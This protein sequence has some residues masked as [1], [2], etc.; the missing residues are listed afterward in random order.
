LNI[1]EKVPF[2]LTRNVVDGL[3]P[4]GTNGMF[5][6]AAER[7]LTVL[8]QNSEALLTILSAIVSDPLYRWSVSPVKK[9]TLQRDDDGRSPQGRKAADRRELPSHNNEA[10]VQAIRRVREKLQGYED[11]T[12]GEPQ[13]CEGQVQLL[14]NLAKDADI[15]SAMYFGWAPWL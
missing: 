14:V 9:R 7:T 2:R 1:P 5:T 3:G 8:K 6:R 12:F 10:A 13:S 11:G 15:L 4:T